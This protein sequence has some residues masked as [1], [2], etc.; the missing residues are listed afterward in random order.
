MENQIN[1]VTNWLLKY[2]F[3]DNVYGLY[4]Y[5][6]VFINPYLEILIPLQ[7]LRKE[8]EQRIDA[9]QKIVCEPQLISKTD[10][11]YIVCP[12]EQIPAHYYRLKAVDDVKMLGNRITF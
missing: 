11:R 4:L 6:S 7:V 3:R 10:P 5:T 9:I 8:I 2:I 1:C 12:G